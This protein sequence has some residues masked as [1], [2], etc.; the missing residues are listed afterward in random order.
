MCDRLPVEVTVTDLP[1]GA[2]PH[3]HVHYHFFTNA[4]SLS[5]DDRC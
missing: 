1:G 2:L 5:V 4:G 3:S